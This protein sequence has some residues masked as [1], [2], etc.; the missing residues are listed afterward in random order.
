MSIIASAYYQIII[1]GRE[2]DDKRYSMIQSLKVED[3]DSGSD[4]VTIVVDDP[5]LEFLQDA[6]FVQ[7]ATI[8]VIHGLYRG[9]VSTF[10]GYISVIDVS[11]PS[12]GTPQLTIHCMDYTHIMNRVKRKRTWTKMRRSDIAKEIFKAYGLKYKVDKTDSVEDSVSQNDT[13]IK[14]LISLAGEEY[15]EY[16]V[17]VENRTGYFVKRPSLSK[18]SKFLGYRCDNGEIGQFNPRINKQT[19]RREVGKSDVNLKDKRIDRSVTNDTVS[20]PQSGQS[21]IPTEKIEKPQSWVYDDK[22]NKWTLK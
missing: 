12:S 11:L 17:Y 20:R 9:K 5:D 6:I 7:D 21:Y 4:L 16:I 13:D 8:K 3:T 18:P 19:K 2:I 10:D 22:N 1:N 15:E 14:F